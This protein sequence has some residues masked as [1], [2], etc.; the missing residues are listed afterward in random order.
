MILPMFVLK[1]ANIYNI[2]TAISKKHFKRIQFL[3]IHQF[4]REIKGCD[5]K[6]D[7][8]TLTKLQNSNIMQKLE[9]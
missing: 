9:N 7:N 5:N 6:T 8:K 1:S 3:N 2:F 4:H